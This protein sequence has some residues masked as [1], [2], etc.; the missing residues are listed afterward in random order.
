[1]AVACGTDLFPGQVAT[2]ASIR[3]YTAQRFRGPAGCHREHTRPPKARNPLRVRAENGPVD[4]FYC[5][6]NRKE[7]CYTSPN[8]TAATPYY[9]KSEAGQALQ[10][11]GA[12]CTIKI[13]AILL[14]GCC[15]PVERLVG[16]GNVVDAGGRPE[17]RG[18]RKMIAKSA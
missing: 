15:Q 14:A 12:G 7:T 3:P 18:F 5:A 10:D 16:A 8:R 17:I 6:Y 1:M 11:C 9:F 13:P 4:A 2:H